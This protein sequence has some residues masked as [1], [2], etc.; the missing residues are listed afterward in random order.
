MR[1]FIDADAC[2]RPIKDIVYRAV[3]RT[4]CPLIMIT[5]QVM[6]VP[7]SSLITLIHVAAG[8]DG[9]DD[10]IV[11]MIEPGDLVITADIPLADRVVS[12]AAYALDPR[13]KLHTKETIKHR[14]ALR[15]LMDQLRSQGT[16]TGGPGTFNQKDRKAFADNLD[17]FLAK[18]N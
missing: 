3:N 15:N 8:A 17:M 6:T 18:H 10:K 11:E 16:L 1:L 2:P 9:A 14:L 5:N 7:D 13:G 4:N 12:K